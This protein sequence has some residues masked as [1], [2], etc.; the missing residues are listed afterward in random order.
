MT[1]EHST[2]EDGHH[3]HPHLSGME[4]ILPPSISKLQQPLQSTPK[5]DRS[6]VDSFMLDSGFLPPRP[7]QDETK[8][9]P[10]PPPRD[11]PLQPLSNLAQ[12][13]FVKN[14]RNHLRT[15]LKAQQ[16]ASAEARASVAALRRLAFR[17]AINISVKEKRIANAA[18]SL[19]KSRKGDYAA[20]RNAEK[21]IEALKKSLKDEERKNRE[22]LQTLDRASKLTLQCESCFTS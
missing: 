21:K 14:Q 11:E 12:L 13:S 22:I 2:S 7:E 4:N 17:L 19:A 9:S 16:V 18:R 15:E 5:L 6:M 1:S 10:S 20:T 8:A 3:A